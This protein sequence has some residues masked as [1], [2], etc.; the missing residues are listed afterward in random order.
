M[1]KSNS[2]AVLVALALLV[3]PVAV[4]ANMPPPEPFVLGIT[5][6]M[7]PDGLRITSVTKGSRA[8]T[9]GL[10]AGDL[11]LGEDG[12]YVK[13]LKPDELKDFVQ[14]WH[15]WRADLVIVR[16]GKEILSVHIAA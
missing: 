6:T 9:A 3:A 1:R 13:S 10:K 14:G 5:A 8:D 4:H 16:D 2:R 15:H 12:R 11:I 7:T